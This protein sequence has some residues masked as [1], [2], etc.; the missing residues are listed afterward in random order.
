M[1]WGMRKIIIGLM[2]RDGKYSPAYAAAIT[3]AT[4]TVGPIIPP[5]GLLLLIVSNITEQ[6]I[7]RVIKEVWPFII[8]LSLVLILITFSA[9]FVLWFPRMLGCQG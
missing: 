9:D 7:R 5:Y 6:P 4:A 2:T 3:A 1:R 8:A